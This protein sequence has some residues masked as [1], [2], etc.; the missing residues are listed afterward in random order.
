MMDWVLEGI[1]LSRQ[2]MARSELCRIPVLMCTSI[3]SSEYRGYF[4]QDE[5]LHADQWL[6]KPCSPDE[7][8]AEVDAVL[9]RRERHAQSTV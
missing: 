8:V 2:M 1:S 9:A 4:P 6:D 5:Y 7:L 3:R